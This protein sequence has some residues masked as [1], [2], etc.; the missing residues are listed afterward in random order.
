MAKIERVKQLVGLV[1]SFAK[2]LSYVNTC[3]FAK[4]LSCVNT[5]SNAYVNNDYHDVINYLI[6]E[7]F[8]N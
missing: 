5:C 8:N 4:L 3:S 1:D 7:I 2:L 6:N